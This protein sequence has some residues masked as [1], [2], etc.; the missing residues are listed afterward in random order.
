MWSRLN[1]LVFSVITLLGGTCVDLVN[2]FQCHCPSGWSGA[3]CTTPGGNGGTGAS[4]GLTGGAGAWPFWI[5]YIVVG[6]LVLLVIALIY[7]KQKNKKERDAAAA[8][9][10]A[11]RAE[12][13]ADWNSGTMVGGRPAAGRRH[14]R[15]SIAPLMDNSDDRRRGSA[16]SSMS[17][18][19]MGEALQSPPTSSDSHAEA[20]APPLLPGAV[21]D[22]TAPRSEAALVNGTRETH[23]CMFAN[24][25]LQSDVISS[26]P[27]LLSFRWW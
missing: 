26:F 3:T 17:S 24:V 14:S 25:V 22:T 7:R 13:P 18:F 19:F 1:L 8:A 10:G 15:N 16:A 9:G 2:A 6:V 4:T 21:A 12:S 20:H 23:A 5:V 27:F 11:S